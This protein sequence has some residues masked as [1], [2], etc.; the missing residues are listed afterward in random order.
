MEQDSAQVLQIAEE[1]VQLN[2]LSGKLWP[3]LLLPGT[4]PARGLQVQ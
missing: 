1:K 4:S 3:Q 2:C